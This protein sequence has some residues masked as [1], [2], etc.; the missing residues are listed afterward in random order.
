MP[1]SVVC[2]SSR[3]L[4]ESEGDLGHSPSSTI[5]ESVAELGGQPWIFGQVCHWQKY[6]CDS[7]SGRLGLSK[8]PRLNLPGNHGLPSD[9]SRLKCFKSVWDSEAQEWKR[10]SHRRL[11]QPMA[12]AHVSFMS[13]FFL[14]AVFYMQLLISCTDRITCEEKQKLHLFWW[15]A[16]CATQCLNLCLGLAG[17]K[18]LSSRLQLSKLNTGTEACE[19]WPLTTSGP[20]GEAGI[21]FPGWLPKQTHGSRHLIDPH[22]AQG[23]SNW[24]SA[25]AGSWKIGVPVQKNQII[26]NNSQIIPIIQIKPQI[27]HKQAETILK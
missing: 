2:V 17:K 24:N 1:W 19:T 8:A 4:A 5:Y 10:S 14:G 26:Q 3:S 15:R 12:V 25:E 6:P 22:W 23:S 16:L 27:I 11:G 7:G 20:P 18:S 13:L 21:F 9:D